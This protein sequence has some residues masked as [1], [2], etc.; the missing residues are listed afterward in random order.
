VVLCYGA[1]PAALVEAADAGAAAVVR[2]T[3]RRLGKTLSPMDAVYP[4]RF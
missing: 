2:Q 3:P 4:L 1:T